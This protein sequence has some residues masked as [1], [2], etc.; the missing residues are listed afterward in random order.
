MRPPPLAAIA[1]LP[2]L[3]PDKKARPEQKST[4][5]PNTS[6]QPITIQP[7]VKQ[8][9]A[10]KPPS[11]PKPPSTAPPKRLLQLQGKAPSPVKLVENVAVRDRLRSPERPPRKI[12]DRSPQRPPWRT[13]ASSHDSVPASRRSRSRSAS[14]SPVADVVAPDGF[15]QCPDCRSLNSSSGPW[16]MF[17]SSCDCRKPLQSTWE[18]GDWYCE[19]CGNHNYKGRKRCNNTWCSSMTTKPGDWICDE[20]GNHNY[21]S[22][23]FC[24]SRTRN[25]KKP[26]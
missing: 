9:S 22:R 11:T 21:S 18:D 7:I 24:N 8:P 15:W 25:G 10:Q 16:S 12:S 4:M 2:Q 3:A 5:Q 6:R 20:C 19:M 17:C 23:K 1:P 14:P 26:C 13:P